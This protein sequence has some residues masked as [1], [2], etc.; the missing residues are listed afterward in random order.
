MICR[1]AASLCKH[2]FRGRLC[3]RPEKSPHRGH[4]V[5][6]TSPHRSMTWHMSIPWPKDRSAALW[7]MTGR[8]CPLPGWKTVFSP[9]FKTHQ[10]GMQKRPRTPRC[11]P[12]P[13][14]RLPGCWTDT[15]A[16]VI[17]HKVPSYSW[18]VSLAPEDLCPMFGCFRDLLPPSP[19]ASPP[20]DLLPEESLIHNESLRVWISYSSV[21]FWA[22]ASCAEPSNCSSARRACAGVL[23]SSDE[24]GLTLL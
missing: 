23:F 14:P 24:W 15:D 16:R 19:S 12:E 20:S 11:G 22:S 9:R 8:P 3:F 21:S 1:P 13:R 17:R 10:T 6:P 2:R 7:N 4:Q 18:P 5:C